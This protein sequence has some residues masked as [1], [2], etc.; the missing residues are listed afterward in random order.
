MR[1]HKKVI[2]I[3]TAVTLVVLVAACS[4]TD[5]GASAGGGSTAG[6]DAVGATAPGVTADSVRVGGVGTNSSAGTGNQ[7]KSGSGLGAQARFERANAEGGVAGRDIEFVGMKDDTGDA[8]RSLQVTRELVQKDD[9]FAVV[10]VTSPVFQSG[11]DFLVENK[12]PFFGWGITPAFCN[13]DFAFGFNGC[14]VPTQP[15]NEVSTAAGGL[16]ADLVAGE[17]GVPAGTTVALIAEETPGGTFGVMVMKAAMIAAGLD[18][19]YSESPIPAN[20]AISDWSPYVQAIMTADGGQPP[21]V[22]FHVTL[23]N[24]SVALGTALDRAGFDGIQVDAVSYNPQR[25]QDAESRQALQG[26]YVF[27]PFAP[28]ETD[29]VAVD[30]M[31]EDLAAV[32][33]DREDLT[34]DMAIGY[35]TADL[36]V[37]ALAATG[38][39]LTRETFLATLNGGFT[40]D[41]PDG[42]GQITYPDGHRVAGAC[43][44]LVQVDGEAFEPT[45]PLTC[46]GTTPLSIIQTGG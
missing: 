16:V 26:R 46:Y 34:Q 36:F 44:S 28:F 17:G 35:W 5:D 14:L 39:D 6:G 32:G 30:Q 22:M 27:L 25:L 20:Q 40:H 12:V 4:A 3:A 24:N 42:V 8:P 18:V 11:G 9:V 37:A 43:G 33:V 29:S 41:V 7:G 45:I 38:E 1:A 31:I 15:D 2:A 23:P 10:P 19:V 21:D 13:N